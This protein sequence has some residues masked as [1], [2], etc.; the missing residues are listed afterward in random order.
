M[1]LIIFYTLLMC[2]VSYILGCFSTAS[3]LARYFKYKNI[4]K[5][6]SGIADTENMFRYISKPLGV[7]CGLIDFAK[8]YLFLWVLSLVFDKI[9]YNYFFTCEILLFVFGLCYIAGHCLPVTNKFKGGRGIFSYIGL[10][11]FFLP[12]PMLI[13]VVFAS[14]IVLFF[15]QYRFAQFLIVLAPPIWGYLTPD[16]NIGFVRLLTIAALLMGL[17]NFFVAKRCGEI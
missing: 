1:T 4:Y 15:K 6:G 17:L 5:I 12:V 3:V 9:G 16:H 8:M 11:S 13:L 14:L 7:L 2:L 10:I